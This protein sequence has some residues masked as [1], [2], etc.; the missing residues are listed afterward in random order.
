MTLPEPLSRSPICA[1]KDLR[2][3]T[4]TY[5][6]SS[7]GRSLCQDIANSDFKDKKKKIK[8]KKR[9]G[10]EVGWEGEKETTF[11]FDAAECH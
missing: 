4:P 9:E 8:K 6:P 11:S 10:R 5:V 2:A 1:I 7:E 3:W